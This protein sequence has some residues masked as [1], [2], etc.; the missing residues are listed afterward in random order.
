MRSYKVFAVVVAICVAVTLSVG[1]TFAWVHSTDSKF[2]NIFKLG[3]ID[4]AIKEEIDG[5][6]KKNVFVENNGVSPA[7]VRLA[8]V[9]EAYRGDE[10]VILPNL[11]AEKCFNFEELSVGQGGSWTKGAD[12]YYY[13]NAIV[14]PNNQTDILFRSA[15]QKNGLDLPDGVVL[16]LTVATELIQEN[17]VQNAWGVTVSSGTLAPSL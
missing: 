16:S 14:E 10:L 2:D 15:T 4:G 5:G 17:G 11:T 13:H 9:V 6:A 12:G 1:I 3:S 8:L 7:Y